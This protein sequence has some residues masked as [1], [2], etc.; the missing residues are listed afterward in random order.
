MRVCLDT[1]TLVLALLFDGN[2]RRLL[3][4]AIGGR[5]ELVLSKWI[6][7]ELEEVL[8][9][10]FDVPDRIRYGYIFR[11]REVSNL[12]RPKTREIKGEVPAEGDRK[13]V[14]TAVV[15]SCEYLIT[16][17]KKLLKLGEVKK[18]KIIRTRE[19]LEKLK[20]SK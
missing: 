20:K 11:L 14:G 2:E 8:R 13:V 4:Y 5:F 1:N 10:K 16:G 15:G 12:V 19:L 17:D 6:L 9:T 18:T 3:K 7:S